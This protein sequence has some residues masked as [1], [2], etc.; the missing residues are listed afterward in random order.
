MKLTTPFS[1]IKN[2][3]SDLKRSA[4]DKKK[5]RNEED[6]LKLHKEE[7]NDGA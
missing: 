6:W 4:K 5:Y 2:A 1:I 3:L 7:N